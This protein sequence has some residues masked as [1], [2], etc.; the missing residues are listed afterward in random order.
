VRQHAKVEWLR[1]GDKNSKFFHACVRER[2]NRNF[3]EQIYDGAGR[4]CTTQEDIEKAF[5]NYFE[6]LFT[7]TCPLNIEK[8]TN[9]ILGKIT[10]EMNAHLEAPFVEDEI[11]ATLSQMAPLKALGPNGFTAKFYQ[12]N[13]PI[14]GLEVCKAVLHFFNNAKMDENI[15]VTHI[16]LIPKKKKD[17]SNVSNFRPISLCNVTYKI[18]SEVLANRLM[19]VLPQLISENQSAFI[20]GRLITNNIL[21]SYK[22][23]HTMH[24]RMWSKVEVGFIG[25]KLDM[26]KAYDRVEWIF[27]EGVLKKWVSQERW[28]EL[29]MECVH[30]VSYSILVNRQQVGNIRL[31]RGIRQGDPLSPYLFILCAESLSALLNQAVKNGVITG[32]PTSKNGPRMSHLFFAD[33]SLLFCKANAVEWRRLLRI[34]EDYEV[35][36]G[37]KLNK[38]KTSICFSRK[39]CMEKREEISR[40]LG[41]QATQSYIK[42]LGLPTLVG[43]SRI[44]SFQNLK[45]RVWKCLQNWKKI[46]FCL[47]QGRRSF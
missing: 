4:M 45:D 3:I 20:P 31:S 6:D 23:L 26:S 42:Y 40:L 19:K 24:S 12:Q 30:T 36:S 2:Q 9:A 11:Q 14:V 16:A 46:D 47:K 38:D 22:T 43:K 7:L 21:A 27:L 5:V 29:I 32:V 17:P 18:I 39:T 34:L 28:I 8:C 1:N 33:D 41:F 44:K 37:Q 25:I 15:N 35:T 10:M 13:W